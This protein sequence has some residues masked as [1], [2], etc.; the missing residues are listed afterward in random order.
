M[1]LGYTEFSFGY[2]FTEN[3]IR[4]SAGRPKGAPIFP[5]LVQEAQLGYDVRIDFP[6]CPI[7]FQY[8]L[9]ELMVRDTATEI[10]NHKLA[11]IKVP[12]FRMPL[13]RRD[14]SNQHRR[15]MELENRYPNAVFYATPRIRN[16]DRFNTAY[17]GAKVHRKS[18]F[19]SPMDIGPLPD[20]K[21]HTIAYRSGLYHAWLYSDPRQIPAKDYGGVNEILVA[22]FEDDRF[23]T[24]EATA[25][26]VR[27]EIFRLIPPKLRQAADSIRR[28]IVARRAT[29]SGR[30]SIDDRT[31]HVAEELLVSRE[32][33]RVGLGLDMVIAQPAA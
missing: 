25:S 33:A 12:F 22:L 28:R 13:M 18:V 14:L 9:P 23:R 10:A 20:N 31:R 7:F 16:V 24:V 4:S 30:P 32:I 8:K 15:L 2:A 1:K 19:F 17:N 26:N 6:A 3:L 21:Q 27:E 5:N 11:G 29:P